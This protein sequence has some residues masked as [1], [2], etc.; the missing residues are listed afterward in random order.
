MRLQNT[1]FWFQNL[2]WKN[3]KMLCKTILSSKELWISADK[4]LSPPVFD[5]LMYFSVLLVPV[6]Y[7]QSLIF[8]LS[9]PLPMQVHLSSLLLSVPAYNI[10]TLKWLLWCQTNLIFAKLH[11][12]LSPVQLTALTVNLSFALCSNVQ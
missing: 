5:N 2:H 7:L 10:W 8:F 12:M 4:M 3:I 6:T 9:L 11:V 1:F